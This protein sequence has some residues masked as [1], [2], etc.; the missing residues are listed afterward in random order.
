M[1]MPSGFPEIP[2]LSNPGNS[3][4]ARI[5]LADQT[6]DGLADRLQRRAAN[7]VGDLTQTAL[8]RE[9][10]K[11]AF[12]KRVSGESIPPYEVLGPA[13]AGE[14]CT[15]CGKGGGAEQIGIGGA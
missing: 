5:G 14:R 15:L 8:E 4:S 10:F 9:R 6:I 13:Q 2:E 12:V 3:P 7:H 1:P 11:E